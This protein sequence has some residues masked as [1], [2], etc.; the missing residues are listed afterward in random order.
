MGLKRLRSWL[1]KF[2]VGSLGCFYC[3]VDSKPILYF[4]IGLM[5]SLALTTI[6]TGIGF[7]LKGFFR[8]ENTKN[9][10]FEAEERV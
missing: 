2:P 7:W 4:F 10:V 5:G 8:D 1:P 9:A 6:M 3:G